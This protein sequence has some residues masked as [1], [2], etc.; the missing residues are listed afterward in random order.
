MPLS[1]ENTF[2]KLDTLLKPEKLPIDLY[3]SEFTCCYEQRRYQSK[4]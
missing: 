4:Y 1:E 3:N 2:F